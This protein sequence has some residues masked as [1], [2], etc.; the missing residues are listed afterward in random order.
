MRVRFVAAAFCLC[1]LWLATALAQGESEGDSAPEPIEATVAD[2]DWMVGSWAGD[3]F[4]G[5]IEEVVLPPSN[6]AMPMTFRAARGGVVGF[7]EFILCEQEGDGVVMRIHHFSPGM[8]RWEDEPVTYDLVELGETSALFTERE[9]E[10]E[11]SR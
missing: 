1:G 10:A 7:Y 9:D 6:G 11:R 3:G 4:G 5:R 8:K 2:L